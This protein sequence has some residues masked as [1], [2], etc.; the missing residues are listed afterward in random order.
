MLYEIGCLQSQK[1]RGLYSQG[2]AMHE[3]LYPFGWSP[4]G[5]R[6]RHIV[7]FGTFI[8]FSRFDGRLTPVG[9]VVSY[10]DIIICSYDNKVKYFF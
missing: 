6:S 7:I 10:Y 1:Y 8:R 4:R 9:R 3:S 5:A 2:C